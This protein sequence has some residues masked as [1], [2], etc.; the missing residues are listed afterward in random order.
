MTNSHALHD[1]V[2]QMCIEFGGLRE[3]DVST[4]QT[5]APVCSRQPD[6]DGLSELLAASEKERARYRAG[7]VRKLRSQDYQ[8]FLLRFGALMFGD[9]WHEPPDAPGTAL[10]DFAVQNLDKRRRQAH[11]LGKILATADPGQ[12]HRLRIA[13]KKLRYSSEMFGSLFE[14]TGVKP[15]VDAL[16]ELQDIL[17]VLNDLA[18]AHR[19]SKDWKTGGA[20]TPW[21]SCA[22]GSRMTGQNSSR[23]WPKHG[24]AL[25]NR[26]NSGS[27]GRWRVSGTLNQ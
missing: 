11:K 6:N 14:A 17:G 26:R 10:A 2:A 22:A 9:Y 25:P 4:T 19:R 15:D 24:R 21:S 1:Q 5:L 3:W 7:V 18:V 16:S 8:R 27:S 23:N 13:C 12:L 20:M